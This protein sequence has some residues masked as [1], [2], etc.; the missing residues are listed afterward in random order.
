M[1]KSHELAHIQQYLETSC[2]VLDQGQGLSSKL[3]NEQLL[4]CFFP[5]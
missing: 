1:P 5:L 2:D 4:F 3:N